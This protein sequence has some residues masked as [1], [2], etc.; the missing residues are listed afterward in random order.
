MYSCPKLSRHAARGLRSPSLGP[1]VGEREFREIANRMSL[2]F[3]KWDCQVVDVST[4]FR[5]PL[6]IDD[7]TWRELARTAEALAAEL[8]LAERELIECSG[9]QR[10]MAF[11]P[12]C[13]GCSPK[14]EAEELRPPQFA[15]SASIFTAQRRLASLG[16]E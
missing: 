13:G 14:H 10:A 2:E 1:A 9:L 3:F 5:Q 15:P 16:G 6:L 8:I 7:A 11:P 4:L 12:S